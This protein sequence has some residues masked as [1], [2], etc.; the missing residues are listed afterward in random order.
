MTHVAQTF[1][2]EHVSFSAWCL[3]TS[4]RTGM[5][6]PHGLCC[7][8]F[9]TSRTFSIPSIS[10]YFTSITS[11]MLVGTARPTNAASMGNSRWPR[12]INTQS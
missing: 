12:S 8:Y 7:Y 6:D 10:F 5:S 3:S 9:S 11:R 4:S 1:V 2:S